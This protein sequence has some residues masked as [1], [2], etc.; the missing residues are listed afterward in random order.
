MAEHFLDWLGPEPRLAWLDVGCGTGALAAAICRVAAPAAV[1]ACDPSAP[2]VDHARTR[3]TDPRISVAIAGVDALPERPGG[4]DRVVSGLVLNFLP[5]PGQ[6][7]ARMRARTRPGGVVAAYVWDYAGRMEFL[8]AFWDEAVAVD[9]AASTLD[10][11]ARFPLCRPEALETVFR[12]T[13]VR[14]VTAG[15]LEIAT[16]FASFAD[17][18]QPFLGGTGPAPAYVA[19]LSVEKREELRGRLERRLATAPGGAVHLV[20]RAWAV[21]GAVA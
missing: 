1:V 9:A 16:R 13:G 10:E 11:G 8:R 17:Y 15:A 2:F 6:A 5:D 20:A 3:M 18:W 19:S 14:D 4:F 12:R 21:R 7:V